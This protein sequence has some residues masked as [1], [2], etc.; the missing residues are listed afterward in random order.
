MT[1]LFEELRILQAVEEVADELWNHV[2]K[3]DNFSKETVGKQL[4]RSVDS[5]GANIAESYGRFHFGEKLQFLYYA[6][7]SLYE[8]KYW[9]NRGYSRKLFSQESAEVTANELSQIAHQLNTLAKVTKDQR[10]SVSKNKIREQN[11]PY[12]IGPSTNT[13]SENWE[14]FTQE[15]IEAFTSLKLRRPQKIDYSITQ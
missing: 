11:L 15:E 12:S 13:A 1:I 3:W 9:L 6:R 8:T 4:V 5:I 14:L 7:G 2:M 10:K